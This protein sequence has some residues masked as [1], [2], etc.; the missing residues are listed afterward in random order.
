MATDAERRNMPP[1]LS[2]FKNWSEFCLSVIIFAFVFFLFLF[3]LWLN[4]L[5]QKRSYP[6]II[7][8]DINTEICLF[9]FNLSGKDCSEFWRIS[10][11]LLDYLS[12]SD[13]W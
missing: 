2:E 6:Q 10:V 3:M 5:V 7:V 12:V 9:F 1:G 8:F 11:R 13:F 4:L